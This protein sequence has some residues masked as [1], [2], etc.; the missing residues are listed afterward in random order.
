MA[1]LLLR[2]ET[3]YQQEQRQEGDAPPDHTQHDMGR[4]GGAVARTARLSD[5]C[6]DSSVDDDVGGHDL[7]S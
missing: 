3:D 5:P 6:T 4:Y 2:G 7:E 1:V